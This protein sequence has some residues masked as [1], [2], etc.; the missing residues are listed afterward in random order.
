MK[1]MMKFSWMLILPVM[2]AAAVI[3]NASATPGYS[4][5]PAV[6]PLMGTVLLPNPEDCSQ[7]FSCS[8]GVPILMD[9]PDMLWF[10]NELDVC[11]FPWAIPGNDC[12][13]PVGAD[14]VF[15]CYPTIRAREG[16]VTFFCGTCDFVPNSAPVNPAGIWGCT[17][18]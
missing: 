15:M 13:P 8:N 18:Q 9:C 16:V 1:K 17:Q 10:N 12:K 11:D 6:D 3:W 2:A 4:S 7:F 14:P 5:C